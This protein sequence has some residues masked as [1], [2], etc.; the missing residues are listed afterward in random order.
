MNS[1]I[2]AT[3][4]AWDRSRAFPPLVA[5]VNAFAPRW[6]PDLLEPQPMATFI[7]SSENCFITGFTFDV[8]GGRTTY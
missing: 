3:G 8:T 4:I 5:I 2:N 6:R 7:V 1:T